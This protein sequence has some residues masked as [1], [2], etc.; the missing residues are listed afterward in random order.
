VYAANLILGAGVLIHAHQGPAVQQ[1]MMMGTQ[2]RL[3]T[4]T[5]VACTQINTMNFCLENTCALAA[6]KL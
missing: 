3:Q 2:L 4:M 5:S 1:Q 6:K